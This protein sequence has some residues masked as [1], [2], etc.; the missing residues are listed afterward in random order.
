MPYVKTIDGTM[1]CV[2]LMIVLLV[3]A[4]IDVGFVWLL[5][6]ACTTV[7]PSVGV[8]EMPFGTFLAWYGLGL[9][10]IRVLKWLLK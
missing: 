5:W 4:G 8:P 10:G 2:A 6:L 3:W 7:G 1:G 9:V